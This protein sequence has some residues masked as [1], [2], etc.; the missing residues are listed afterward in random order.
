LLVAEGRDVVIAADGLKVDA[1][2]HA[3]G[4]STAGRARRP[5]RPGH[6]ARGN[7]PLLTWITSIE[8]RASTGRRDRSHSRPMD[9]ASG[10]E[11][12]RPRFRASESGGG[13]GRA[14]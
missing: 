11:R 8:E 1:D 2:R 4:L 5:R 10:R 3:G 14:G 7:Q 6:P 13:A 12:T 9:R